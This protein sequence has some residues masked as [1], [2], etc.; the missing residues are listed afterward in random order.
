MPLK[1]KFYLNFL[2]VGFLV[3]FLL[4]GLTW[5]AL[6]LCTQNHHQVDGISPGHGPQLIAQ[7]RISKSFRPEPPTP[8]IRNK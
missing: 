1:A 7:N 6:G 3:L 8:L 4:Q 5:A 2:D